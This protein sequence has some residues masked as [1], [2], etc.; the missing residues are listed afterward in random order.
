MIKLGKVIDFVVD[1]FYPSFE[2]LNKKTKN[3]NT[4]DL[5]KVIIFFVPMVFL[6]NL[7]KIIPVITRY[8]PFSLLFKNNFLHYRFRKERAFAY[9]VE[10]EAKRSKHPIH[11]FFVTSDRY[12]NNYYYQPKNRK[13]EET[14]KILVKIIEKKLKLEE[15]SVFVKEEKKQVFR[16]MIP[17][18]ISF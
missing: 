1:N 8:F 16:I 9:Y 2:R 18:G 10:R 14:K 17:E 5:I 4:I 7:P 3:V 6:I 12:F 11:F 13:I 15:G